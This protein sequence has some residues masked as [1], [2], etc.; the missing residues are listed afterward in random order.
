MKESANLKMNQLRSVWENKKVWKEKWTDLRVLQDNINMLIMAV[1][2]GEK[3]SE[4]LMAGSLPIW[5]K[6]YP[7]HPRGVISNN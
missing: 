4:E 2:K 3:Y 6:Y 7:T 5:G 1:S